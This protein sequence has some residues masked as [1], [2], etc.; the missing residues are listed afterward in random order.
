M[1][2]GITRRAVVASAAALPFLA[3]ADNDRTRPLRVSATPSIFRPMFEALR[4]QFEHQHP[5]VRVEIT[6]SARDQDQ[7]IL[8][9]LRRNLIKDLPD[10]SF[11]GFKQ[12]RVLERRRISIPLN[13]LVAHDA[14]W[15]KHYGRAV[16]ESASVNGSAIGLGVALSVPI[17]YYNANLVA[18]VLGSAPM[19]ADWDGLVTLVE[20]LSKRARPGALGGFIQH[21]SGSWN[22]LGMVESLGGSMMN[23]DESEIAF[24]NAIG[25]HA[26]AIHAAFGRAG[27]ARMDMDREQARQA[28]AA[29]TVALL[30]DSSSSLAMLEKQVADR[31]PLGTARMPM[32]TNGH[33]PA[34]GIA[35][36]MM[37]RDSA[38]QAAAWQFMRYVCGPAGQM[39]IGKSTGYLPANDIVVSRNDMLGSYYEARPRVRPVVDSLPF[40]TRWYAFPGDN[41]AK[42]DSVIANGVSSVI[43]LSQTPDQALASM[44]RS[45]EALLPEART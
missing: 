5:G 19:P 30:I 40:A 21:A 14:D 18:P 23:A 10:I 45:V 7:Q 34:S 9:T 12:L 3:R 20:A 43:S 29:G 22:Y 33:L 39:L 41:S 38:R 1:G 15:S 17:V 11:E 13:A 25:R 36:V 26:L 35:A 4:S 27:Q 16:I 8:N 32:A 6:A 2:R 37:T 42:I 24:D 31:F 44:R 28:F